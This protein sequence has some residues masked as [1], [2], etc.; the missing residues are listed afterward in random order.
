MDLP[1]SSFRCF[2]I[3]DRHENPNNPLTARVMVNRIWHWL[4]GQGLVSTV[5]NFGRMGAEPT[6]PELLDHLAREFIA[7]GWSVK[8]LIVKSC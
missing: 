1:D 5:D 2:S 7:H 3:S 8:Y 6:H 4:F